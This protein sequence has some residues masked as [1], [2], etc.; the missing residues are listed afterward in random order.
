[1]F[2]N[3]S[4]KRFLFF[5]RK[6]KRKK[7]KYK[8]HLVTIKFCLSIETQWIPRGGDMDIWKVT[9]DGRFLVK[10]LYEKL[11]ST[12]GIPLLHAWGSTVLH[13]VTSF[14][15]FFFMGNPVKWDPFFRQHSKE[16]VLLTSRC[17]LCLLKE[18]MKDHLLLHCDK[19]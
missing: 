7:E 10:S 1:M 9:K 4:K 2:R 17:F 13:K 16:G 14:F 6:R 18:E 5:G 15:F 3:Y 11:A 8:I 19:I 12:E